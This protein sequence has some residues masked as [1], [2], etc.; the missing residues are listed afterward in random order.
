MPGES[1]T[2]N[3][4]NEF[5]LAFAKGLQLLHYLQVYQVYLVLELLLQLTSY[6]HWSHSSYRV[7]TS[8]RQN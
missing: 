1:Q 5:A 3:L 7:A 6:S 4:L 2:R 8:I